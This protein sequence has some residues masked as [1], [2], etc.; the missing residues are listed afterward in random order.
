MDEYIGL[1]QA[2][3]YASGHLTGKWPV[4]LLPNLV[5]KGASNSFLLS[6]AETGRVISKYWPGFSILLTPFVFLGIPW[7]LN[8]LLCAGS[9]LLLHY[10]ARLLFPEHREAPGWIL[11]LSI[12]SPQIIL[13]S[14]SYYSMPAHLFLSLTYAALLAKPTAKRMFFAGLIGSLALMIQNPFPHLIF[15]IPWF[16]YLILHRE[17][18]KHILYLILG[19]IPLLIAF[20]SLHIHARE[21]VFSAHIKSGAIAAKNAAVSSGH[22]SGLLLDTL[23]RMF[24]VIIKPSYGLLWVRLLCFIKLWFWAVPGL[25]TLSAFGFF[26]KWNVYPLNVLVGSFVLIV[27][28]TFFYGASQGHGWGYRYIH[29][30]WMVFPLLATVTI[31]TYCKTTG[32]HAPPTSL[33]TNFR[34]ALIHLCLFSLIICNGVRLV[35][36]YSHINNHLGILPEVENNKYQI[37]F[38]PLGFYATDLIQNDPFMRDPVLYMEGSGIGN[39]NK[40][41]SKY[42]PNA[43]KKA[44]NLWELNKL[45]L[46]ALKDYRQ[47]QSDSNNKMGEG[48]L[49]TES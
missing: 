40:L 15:A 32:N 29:Q 9:L 38:V 31:T 18:R 3:V 47:N 46:E 23:K 1:F 2:K 20:V 26:K 16:L 7:A 39:N 10:L 43:V 17:H 5:Y 44:D 41:I 36:V 49:E 8:P 21:L 30:C 24:R 4:E 12:A 27:L 19:Y 22:K 37:V 14:I 13:N 25:F 48:V 35:Q 33:G 28:A 11:L 45:P 42:F 34:R 6:S